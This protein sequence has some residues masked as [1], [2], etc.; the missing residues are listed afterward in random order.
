MRCFLS[1]L[2]VASPDLLQMPSVL[3]LN[4]AQVTTKHDDLAVTMS[5]AF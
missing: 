1:R 2:P 3:I 5:A 4:F